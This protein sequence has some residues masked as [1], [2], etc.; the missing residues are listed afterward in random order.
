MPRSRGIS[1]SPRSSYPAQ[2]QATVHQYSVR[3]RIVAARPDQY[4]GV[5]SKKARSC[6]CTNG[7][8]AMEAAS[9]LPSCLKRILLRL[10]PFS[11]P[12]FRKRNR[13]EEDVNPIQKF[14]KQAVT[15]VVIGTEHRKR[16]HVSRARMEDYWTFG[17]MNQRSRKRWNRRVQRLHRTGW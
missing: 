14:C 15:A 11:D 12:Q 13:S 7:P 3:R 10:T 16:R 9:V 4:S 8:C 2:M 1:R 6:D 5:P 17:L